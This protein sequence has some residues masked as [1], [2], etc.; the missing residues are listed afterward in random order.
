MFAVYLSLIVPLSIPNRIFIHTIF[1][2]IFPINLHP[3]LCPSSDFPL[4]SFYLSRLSCHFSSHCVLIYSLSFSRLC[5]LPLN[6]C[7]YS[8][9]I[10]S[11]LDTP[12]IQ[13]YVPVPSTLIFISYL[14]HDIIS[15]DT[16]LL[17][18]YMCIVFLV[19]TLVLQYF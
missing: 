8:L 2:H 3:L 5:S 16:L 19:E 10:L 14:T 18:K 9:L 15:I 6:S 7:I 17:D 12:C 1:S 4:L 13:L 11:N